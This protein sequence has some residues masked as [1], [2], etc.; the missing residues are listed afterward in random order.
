RV[1]GIEA[2]PMCRHCGAETKRS[3]QA[4]YCYPCQSLKRKLMRKPQG[5][6][7]RSPEAV[8]MLATF[9]NPRMEA[10]T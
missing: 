4:Q 7:P 10:G 2:V 9:D 5:M 3:K 6:T 1:A 8:A